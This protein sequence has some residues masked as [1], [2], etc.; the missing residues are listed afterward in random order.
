GDEDFAKVL[1]CFR[2]C[3]EFEICP[4]AEI[5]L[6]KNNVVYLRN[7]IEMLEAQEIRNVNYYPISSEYQILGLDR[8][9]MIQA[10]VDVQEVADHS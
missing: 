7:V 9:Q 8:T 6:L 5:P 1:M 3:K 2:D 4:V 10:A